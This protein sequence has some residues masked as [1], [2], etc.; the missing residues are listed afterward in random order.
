MN[1]KI[2]G[3]YRGPAVLI[4]AAGFFVSITALAIY[5][6]E[7]DYTDETLFFLLAVIRYSSVFVCVGSVYL[8]TDSVIQVKHLPAL[9]SAVRIIVSLGCLLYG[10][11]IIFTDAFIMSISEGIK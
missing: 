10:A 4:L 5:L 2:G 9:V 11:G 8:L 6:S 1:I 3:K 7:T